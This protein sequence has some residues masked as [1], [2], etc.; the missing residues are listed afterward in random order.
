MTETDADALAEELAAQVA[1]LVTDLHGAVA[2]RRGGGEAVLEGEPVAAVFDRP[3]GSL[4]PRHRAG[5]PSAA[6][7]AVALEAAG[8]ARAALAYGPGEANPALPALAIACFYVAE[9]RRSDAFGL[10]AIAARQP[11][12]TLLGPDEAARDPEVAE[13][14][15]LLRVWTQ[16]DGGREVAVEVAWPPAVR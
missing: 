12:A 1:E 14:A 6:V 15:A 3:A 4:R 8:R 11:R 16:L 13:G 9:A 5:R 7:V 10:Q 2:L